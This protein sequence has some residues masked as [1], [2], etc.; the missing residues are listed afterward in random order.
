MNLYLY[1]KNNLI[2]YLHPEFTAK[3]SLKW[4]KIKLRELLML[5]Y[6]YNLTH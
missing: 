4:S 5:V 6:V 3:I 2:C 1:E